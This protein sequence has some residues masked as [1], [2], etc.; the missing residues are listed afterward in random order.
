[1]WKMLAGFGF[2][3]LVF[4]G[5]EDSST[6]SAVSVEFCGRL[7]HGVMAVGG[8]TT[9]TTIAAGPVICELELSEDAEKSFAENHNKQQVVVIG[10]LRTTAA[11]EVRVR[12]IID[13]R[14]IAKADPA[15]NKDG[16]RVSV[17][18]MLQAADESR[19]DSK[20]MT[21]EAGGQIW[22]CNF[23]ESP[24]L[25]GMAQSLVGNPVQITGT[26][27]MLPKQ[28]SETPVQIKVHSVIN[29]RDR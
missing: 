19:S 13:V 22:T 28:S 21:I 14:K 25:E 1:M 24:Q 11:T 15:K 17:E 3:L 6:D 10:K 9:G 5:S 27:E 7:R 20:E 2:S 26:P 8:E 4:N 16:V 18:G 23:A 29:L 12:R